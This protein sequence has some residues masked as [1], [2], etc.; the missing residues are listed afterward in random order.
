MAS[1]VMEFFN[2]HFYWGLGIGAGLGLIAIIFAII[3]LW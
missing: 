3:R 1:N 2:D